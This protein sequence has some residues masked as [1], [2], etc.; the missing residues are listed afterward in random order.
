MYAADAKLIIDD[1]CLDRQGI[2]VNRDLTDREREAEKHGFSFVEMDGSIGVIGN[3]AGLTMATLD[4]IEYYGG[5]AAD[6]LDVGGGADSERVMH[7]VRLVAG[8]P[9]V[10]VIVVNLL[11]GITRC[12]EVA[13][14]IIAAGAP[15]PVI[16]RIAGDECRGGP[17]AP[18]RK[19]VRDARYYGPCRQKSRGGDRMI[20]GDKKTGIIVTGATGKQGE[21]HIGLMN[22]Y[23]RELGG[24]GVVA[25]VTPKKRGQTVHGIP[26]YNT[27]KEALK[28]QDAA[29][30]V[31]FVPHGAAADSIM[32]A[33]DAGLGLVV[34]ISEYIPVHDTMKGLRLRQDAGL[35]RHWPQ[36][37][38][39][40]RPAG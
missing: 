24:R 23:A 36:L 31:V 18:L 14:G 27:V 1:N 4:L 20:Y 16:V 26:V 37:S 2:A 12:D 17:E 39:A 3:G 8:V 34:A 15:V 21:Y 22:E 6:F 29:A 32:E 38:R 7:A 40:P 13:R 28:E 9:S 25:G 19:R 11:G 35:C 33:A 30:A 10:K 5:R